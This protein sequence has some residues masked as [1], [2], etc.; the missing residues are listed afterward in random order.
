M[1]KRV[2]RAITHASGSLALGVSACLFACNTQPPAPLESEPANASAP[3]PPARSAAASE[4]GA[5]PSLAVAS[6]TPGASGTILSVAAT[7]AARG[8]ALVNAESGVTAPPDTVPL[9]TVSKSALFVGTERVADVLPG[10]LGFDATIKRAGARAALEVLPLEAILRPLHAQKP[11]DDT[12]RLLFD[13]TT[14]Y[15]S[16]IEVLFSTA[17]AGFTSFAVIVASKAGERAVPASTPSRAERDAARLPGAPPSPSFVL[18]RDGVTLTVGDVAIGA[19]CTRGARGV[20]VPSVAGRIDPAAV[21]VCA[22]RVKTMDPMWASVAVA[23]VSAAAELDMQTVMGAV[24]AIVP[25]FPV[26]HFGLLSP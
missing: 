23:S 9:I 25:T 10:P 14:S 16:A 24:A 20:A 21:A 12:V 18:Q 2:V 19:G 5:A 15:R 17:Q 11:T 6:S 22:A 3:T 1:T 13:A 8:V 7:A 4:T 26:V